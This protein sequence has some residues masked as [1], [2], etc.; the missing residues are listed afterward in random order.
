[1]VKYVLA[2]VDIQNIYYGSLN[3]TQNRQQIDYEK[4]LGFLTDE[5]TAYYR[6]AYPEY[7]EYMEASLEPYAYVVQTPRY[8]G[9]AFF[10]F[11]R[12][13]G[14]SLRSKLFMEDAIV[15]DPEV[16]DADWKGTVGSLIQLDMLDKGPDYD[17]VVVV[18][19]SGMYE[20]SFKAMR[21]HWPKVHRIIS[22]FDNTLHQVYNDTPGLVQH[23]IPLSDD[24]LRTRRYDRTQND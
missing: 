10:A 12:S 5:I 21:A 3:Y 16:A 7:G 15:Y 18:S 1:M 23:I 17:A 2:L 19:G 14:Y 4:L 13:L 8:N 22:A 9:T 11:L 24:V 20:R 6:A